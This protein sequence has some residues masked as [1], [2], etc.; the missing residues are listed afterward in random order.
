MTNYENESKLKGLFQKSLPQ[1]LV[2]ICGIAFY[3]FVYHGQAIYA[4]VMKIVSILS[5]I[6]A[7]LAMAY[8]M[9]PVMVFFEKHLLEG[10]EKTITKEKTRKSLSRGI[11]IL[12]TFL[13]F[14]LFLYLLGA[15]VLPLI[16]ENIMNLARTLPSGINNLIKWLEKRGI[17]IEEYLYDAALSDSGEIS[18]SSGAF[19]PNAILGYVLNWVRNDMLGQMSA[20]INHLVGFFSLILNLL[21]ACVVAVYA[22]SSKEIFI[23]Q[24]KMIIYAFTS[25]EVSRSI[26]TL[27]KQSHRIFGGFISGKLIDSLI[28]GCLC[29]VG[30]IILGIP[31]AALVSVIVG[32][33]NIIPF[34]G[35]YLGV[36]PSAFLVLLTD[37]MKAL[38][39]VVFACILQQFDGNILGPKILGESTGL[40]P[41]WIIVAILLGGGLFGIMGMILG[42]PT[43]AVI[44]YLIKTC[45]HYQLEKKKIRIKEL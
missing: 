17:H 8:V 16:Q 22:L 5:P 7:G 18:I 33:T 31:Y 29:F 21:V 19:S 36:I 14:F 6:L 25:K 44:Y 27:L 13:L 10:L 34:F 23:R 12:L 28:I 26:F 1:L 30:C 45:V 32:V 38:I 24:T 43:F 9:N 42:V 2:V 41:F 35:P 11:A 39:F 20:L 37:P 40:S 15:M 4:V 3:F